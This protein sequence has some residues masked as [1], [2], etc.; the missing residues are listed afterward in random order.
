MRQATGEEFTGESQPLLRC[1]RKSLTF[2][3]EAEDMNMYRLC[4][5]YFVSFSPL[6]V[7]PWFNWTPTKQDLVS[8]LSAGAEMEHRWYGVTFFPKAEVSGARQ[9][10]RELCPSF[11]FCHIHTV[12]DDLMGS[13]QSCHP[14]WSWVSWSTTLERAQAPATRAFEQTFSDSASFLP[15]TTRENSQHKICLDRLVWDHTESGL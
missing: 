13:H 11:I 3:N 12:K 2:Q 15:W 7:F 8:S 5:P 14:F 6:C 10:L 9:A 1:W 4:F